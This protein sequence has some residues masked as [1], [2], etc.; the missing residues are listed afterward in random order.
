MPR[1]RRFLVPPLLAVLGVVPATTA[2]AASGATGRPTASTAPVAGAPFTHVTWDSAADWRSGTL[3]GLQRKGERLVVADSARVRNL[4]GRP[5]R[6]GSWT[7]RWQRSAV[8]ELTPSWQAY[9]GPAWVEVSVRTRSA[10]GRTGSWDTVA[11]W[12]VTG[13]GDRRTLRGQGDDVGRVEGGSWSVRE[14]A[15]PQAAWQVRVEM[16]DRT[17]DSAISNLY[18][19]DVATASGPYVPAPTSAPGRAA[20]R[21]V[22]EDVP[23][24]SV[25]DTRAGQRWATP[26]AFVM[27]MEGQGTQVSR[28]RGPIGYAAGRGYDNGTRAS[29]TFSFATA[30][31]STDGLTSSWVTRLADV[32]ALE[33]HLVR[34]RLVVVPLQAGARP[35]LVVGI[36]ADGD[37]IVHDPSAP[38]RA[39]VPQVIPR[40]DFEAD[41]LSSGGLA[42]IVSD[43]I[44]G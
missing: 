22:A 33:E 38:T 35:V 1:L 8:T 11:V 17:R 41:W 29:D 23:S 12:S 44:T 3:R 40:A 2:T 18:R 5:H 10:G 6:V 37:V 15:R 26:A 32:T 16:S 7:S 20:G 43:D 36:E 25:A 27:A 31:L 24:Y 9:S 39:A 42:G 30:F 13:S 34:G 19:L 14:G 4:Q 28:G 21:P